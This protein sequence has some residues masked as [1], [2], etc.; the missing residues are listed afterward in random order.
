MLKAMHSAKTMADQT[1][2]GS[3]MARMMVLLI[4]ME[5]N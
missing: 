4:E 1:K 5:T 3:M 2:T